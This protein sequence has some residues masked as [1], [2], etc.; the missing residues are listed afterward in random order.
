M[1]SCCL[2]QA[3]GKIKKC[4][5]SRWNE[6]QR[7][8][9]MR[10]KSIAIVFERR[11]REMWKEWKGIIM[12]NHNWSLYYIYLPF[13]V[14]IPVYVC[15]LFCLKPLLWKWLL[16]F[17]FHFKQIPHFIKGIILPGLFYATVLIVIPHTTH[18]QN[19]MIIIY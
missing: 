14:R 18:K 15:I 17:S 11:N 9:S 3:N 12:R 5:S 2:I 10:E 4:L 1:G 13:V 19:I 16:S 7:I 8:T 6:W